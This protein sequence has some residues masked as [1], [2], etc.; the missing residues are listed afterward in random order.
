M[1]ALRVSANYVEIPLDNVP[2][3]MMGADIA[4]VQPAEDCFRVTAVV[5]DADTRV[6]IV[7]CDAL[8]LDREVCDRIAK[9]IEEQCGIPFDNILISS[10]HTHHAPM[11]IAV[12]EMQVDSQ[13]I[14][15][16]EEAAVNAVKKSTDYLDSNPPANEADAE[17]FV[18]VGNE[19]TVGKNSR[20][21]LRD[22]GISWLDHDLDE[23]IRPTGPMD[24]DL[25][26]IIFR[27][28]DGSI[29]A[30]I[31]SHSNHNIGWKDK[32]L[33]PG[34]YVLAARESERKHGG[35]F[36]FMPGAFGSTHPM[37]VPPVDERII[38]VSVAI[39][40]AMSDMRMGLFGPLSSA[41]IPFK[42]NIR[43]F[44]DATE[45]TAVTDYCSR[46]LDPNTSKSFIDIF[47]N[48]RKK[49][50]PIQGEERE[51]WIQ[52]IRLGDI[53]IIGVPGELFTTLGMEIKRRSP[54]KYTIVTAIANDYIGYLP[55]RKAFELGGY[56]TWAGLQCPA[57]KGTGEA[58]V[59][60][61]VDLL[62]RAF[63]TVSDAEPVIRDLAAD[64]ALKLQSFYNSLD[65]GARLLF[66]PMG[67]TGAY[68]D[69]EAVVKGVLDG[70]RY[71]VVVE[72]DGKIHG[73]A[74]I[75]GMDGEFPVFGIGVSETLRGMGYGRKIMGRVIDFGRRNRTKKGIDLTVVQTNDRA[76]LLYESFGFRS[77]GVLDGGDGLMYYAMR[78]LFDN[79]ES[80]GMT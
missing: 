65:H 57:E 58:I 22:G 78:L 8:G 73:W 59:D 63:G 44:D 14:K 24:P 56:Q 48:M 79:V 37:D 30:G 67:W 16:L 28:P 54:F 20:F 76:R 50:E 23:K 31:F 52:L 46:Y 72:K 45:D 53:A 36:M 26:V 55:D 64:D 62:E 5:L 1:S 10:T 49:M 33:S 4:D 51:S 43:S 11:T 71:D 60:A 19:A 7:S 75:A 69:F 15:S 29:A 12:L 32:P 3:K 9:S 47:R 68:S 38:R 39:D 42:Y 17:L 77:T 61:S 80:P 25:P 13:F 41:R 74:F 18:A 21:I 70:V 34:F 27:R 66:R 35:V 6:C 2:I 40:E